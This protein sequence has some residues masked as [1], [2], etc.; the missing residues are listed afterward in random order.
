MY[1][2][3]D[4]YN[5]TVENFDILYWIRLI[6]LFFTHG[7][8]IEELVFRYYLIHHLR[9]MKITNS[10]VLILQAALFSMA[11]LGRH[12]WLLL[13]D[14]FVLSMIWGFSFLKTKDIRPVIISHT[15]YNLLVAS[16]MLF[17]QYG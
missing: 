10:L 15:I 9:Q 1:D 11:H 8:V 14:S 12:S 7:G 13:V 5:Y 4:L 17:Y 16:V 2:L 6:S 3:Y